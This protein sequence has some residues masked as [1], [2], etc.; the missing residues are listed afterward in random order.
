MTDETVSESGGCWD[1]RKGRNGVLWVTYRRRRRS[2]LSLGRWP[3][4]VWSFCQSLSR[5][6]L[7]NAQ[8]F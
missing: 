2:A 5:F 4:L 6:R 3:R 1:K 7:K 8:P